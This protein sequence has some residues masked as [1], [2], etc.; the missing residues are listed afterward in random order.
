M[1]RA[2]LFSLP[3]EPQAPTS[4]PTQFLIED[5]K[6]PWLVQSVTATTTT[7]T[8]PVGG[9]VDVALTALHPNE[10]DSP[11]TPTSPRGTTTDD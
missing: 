8:D 3:R 6:G 11:T 10:V 4:E 2:G 1:R 7:L 5:D 9:I